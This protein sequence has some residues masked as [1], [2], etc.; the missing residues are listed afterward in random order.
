[1]ARKG[2][3][4]RAIINRRWPYGVELQAEAARGIEKSA[5]TWGL[6][7]TLEGAPYP[8][9]RFRNDSHYVVFHFKTDADAA[10]FA[11]RFDGKLLPVKAPRSG[12]SRQR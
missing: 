12:R 3:I 7:A 11:A 1:M 6:A 4:T 10:A 9:P 2:E 5:A 8:L